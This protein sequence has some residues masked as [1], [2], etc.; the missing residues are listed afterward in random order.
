ML[1]LCEALYK[2]DESGTGDPYGGVGQ[3]ARVRQAARMLIANVSQAGGSSTAFMAGEIIGA[4]KQAVAIVGHPDLRGAFAARDV[5]GVVAGVA[6][7]AHVPVHP[8]WPYVR[9]GRA[10]MTVLAWLADV[11]DQLGGTGGP[12][13]AIGHPVVGSAVEWIEATLDI[14]VANAPADPRSPRAPASPWSAV[15]A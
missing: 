1:E 14:G 2:L 12:V 8:P 4:L 9:R 11:T 10:G 3:Q 13:V 6:R 5:W 15:G 7:L